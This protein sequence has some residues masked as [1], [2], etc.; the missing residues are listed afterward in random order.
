VDQGKQFVDAELWQGRVVRDRTGHSS[1]GQ[2][3]GF[4][5]MALGG[6]IYTHTYKLKNQV[7]ACRSH[8]TV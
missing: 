5:S 4:I 1:R 7:L 8:H 6:S 3:G 2:A